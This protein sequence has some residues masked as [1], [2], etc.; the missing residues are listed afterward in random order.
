MIIVMLGAPGAGKGTQSKLLQDE[1]NLL[2]ISSGDLL[3][4][5]IRRETALGKVADE[6]ITRG[7][8]VPDQLMIDMIIDR[9]AEPNAER[10]V[11]L[12][13]FPRTLP[14]AAALDEALDMKHKR[15]NAALYINVADGILIER[16]SSRLTCRAKG[17]VFNLRFSLPQV[18]GICDYDGS[19]LYQ[20]PDDTP[21]TAQKRLE[22]YFDQ[23]LPIIGYYRDKGILC[24]VWGD[25][26]IEHVTRDL[27]NCLR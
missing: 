23:T 2:H 15:V 3:R 9:L 8:L 13:G 4:D 14:Q 10:G 18:E 16:L 25:Q 21:E 1:L 17:H 5:N 19:E 22:V 7:E 12:D 6:Y 26:Y 24:E 20:R 11:L 27:L